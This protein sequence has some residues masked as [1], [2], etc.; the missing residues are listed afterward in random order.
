MARKKLICPVLILIFLCTLVACQGVQ[1]GKI[2][3]RTFTP[4][5]INY[6]IPKPEI[7]EL[8]G[9]VPLVLLEDHELPLI[10][11]RVD[12]RTGQIYD[13][14][15]YSGVAAATGT[16]LRQAGTEK[17]P[18]AELNRK[19][20]YM[21]ATLNSSISRESGSVTVT[22]HSRDLETG[23]DL[24][25]QI[26]FYPVFEED[27]V[28]IIRERNIESLERLPDEPFLLAL[29][30]FKQD[31]YE[32]NPRGELPTFASLDKI[33]QANLREFHRR[34][35]HPSNM[36][37]GVSGDFETKDMTARLQK[38]FARADAAPWNPPP[39]VPFP[40][41]PPS[42]RLYFIPK[43]IP[44]SII[45]YGHLTVG[46]RHPD[47]YA[48]QILNEII[49]GGFRSR[50]MQEV[51][52]NLG[53]AYSINSFYSY[54]PDFSVWGAIA[55]TKSKSTV[56]TLTLIMDIIKEVNQN[57]ITQQELDWAK[58]A[59]QNS[60]IFSFNSPFGI[61]SRKTSLMLDRLPSDFLDKYTGRIASVDL[62]Q[63]ND[64]ARRQ[65]LTDK[66]TIVVVG[67]NDA[68][69]CPFYEIGC[70]TVIPEDCLK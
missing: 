70:F 26:L 49:G 50:L 31:I 19:L 60:F 41:T 39:A 55:S 32:N 46:S 68:M 30:K 10:R 16:A 1:K 27:K 48:M 37:V 21:G 64:V 56:K 59:L 66:A 51:R 17:Y 33:T 13:P 44:Q 69:E 35:Y 28:K 67:N 61:V 24:L 40:G 62:A 43:D 5:P 54:Y 52:S 14:A 36:I 9:G 47:F 8:A 7:R 25:E 4:P 2:N 11:L 38:I 29:R 65:L 22:V 18:S 57:G 3:P 20:D 12:M 45:V 15:G 42:Q 23:L 63:A 53:L 58:E 6:E 34:F